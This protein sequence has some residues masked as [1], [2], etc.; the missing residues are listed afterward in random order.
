MAD[1]KQDVL[2][3]LRELAELTLLDEQNPQSF[4]VR[5]YESAAQAIAAQATDLGKLTVKELLAIDGIG[6]STADKIRELLETGKVSRVE[7]L[8]EKHPR[9]V[10]A[11]LQIQGLGPKAVARLRAEL[12]VQSLDDLRRVLAESRLRSLRGFG[13]KS[14]DKLKQA[15]ERLDQ[16]GA[17]SRTPI[18]IALPHAERIVKHLREVP[19]VDQVVY[20][21]SLRRFSETI[22]DIDI[23]VTASAAEP[24]MEALTTM[25]L[26]ERV[27]GRGDRK[28]SVVTRRGIQVD[29]RV[30][31]KHQLGAALLYFTGSKGHNIKLRMRALARGLTLNEYGLSEL[32][33]G[34]VVAS[35][36]EAEIYAALGLAFI[37]PVLREDAGEIEAAEGGRLPRAVQGIYGDFHVH[38]TVS[39]DGRSPLEDVIAAAKE[40]GY[41]ALAITEHAENTLSGVG[42]EALLEQRAKFR[43]VQAELGDSLR[44]LHGVELNIGP[45]GELDYD[46]EFRK[47]FDWC[48]ASVHSHFELDRQRQT[49]RVIKAM[50]DPSVRMIGHLSARMIG[51]RAGID[52]DLDAVFG[53]A[54]KTGTALEI[55]GALPRLDMSVEALRRVRSRDVP[56]VLTSDA[57]HSN[58][59]DRIR[60]AALN[61]ERASI[62][63]ERVVNTW[64][65]ERLLEWLSAGR[66]AAAPSAPA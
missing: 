53:A 39:G 34:K 60:F 18:S 65:A 50:L 8:R 55:N 31:E 21:G 25:V 61:A 1:T 40:R 16:Q 52:L 42:R 41:R 49:E 24:V 23:V 51:H 2:D 10:V 46:L 17:L 5:A 13:P 15:V 12:G 32:E 54:E 19:G 28:T 22:G 64:P 38:T 66:R 44:L 58:E 7:A 48:L 36:T 43:A 14:E 9:S 56:L 11:L 27:L 62:D 29:L 26:V 33:G 37:P 30:V 57:H 47:G 6:K 35:E 4:R 3:M 63:P 59:L 20:C 45:E